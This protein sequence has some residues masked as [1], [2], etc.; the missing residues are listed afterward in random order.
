MPQ[1]VFLARAR[2]GDQHA[3]KKLLTDQDVTNV[4]QTTGRGRPKLAGGRSKRVYDTSQ[5]ST[6]TC[7][8]KLSLLVG[9]HSR[10]PCRRCHAR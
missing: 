8:C 4:V 10:A 6:R 3:L 2:M 7:T 1:K 5:A 9:T